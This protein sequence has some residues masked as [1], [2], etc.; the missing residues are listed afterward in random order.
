[1]KTKDEILKEI[2]N[3]D[4][5]GILDQ[6]FTT[7]EKLYMVKKTVNELVAVGPDYAQCMSAQSAHKNLKKIKKLLEYIG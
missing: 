7:K 4:P 6:P 3:N 5:M 1:M 2:L